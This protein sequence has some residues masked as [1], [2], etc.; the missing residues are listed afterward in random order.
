MKKKEAEAKRGGKGEE[1]FKVPLLN[2]N[3]NNSKSKI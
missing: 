3:N 2:D 1:H